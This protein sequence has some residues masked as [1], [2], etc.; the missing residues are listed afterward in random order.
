M[1][2]QSTNLTW[3]VFTFLLFFNFFSTFLLLFF[4]VFSTLTHPQDG[5]AVFFLF[6]KLFSK[7]LLP[8]KLF[9]SFSS[10]GMTQV[11]GITKD[12]WLDLLGEI[13]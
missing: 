6:S 1:K 2:L 13:G 10:H 12:G 3:E 7:N 9:S 4:Y 5:P 11:D 8:G